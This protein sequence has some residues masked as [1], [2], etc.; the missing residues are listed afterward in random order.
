MTIKRFYD[1]GW[2]AYIRGHPFDLD[3]SKTWQDGWIDA[4]EEFEKKEEV[5][6]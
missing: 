5:V 3:A 6:E 1:E 2:N 4:E